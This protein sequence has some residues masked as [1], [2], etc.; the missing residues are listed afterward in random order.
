MDEHPGHHS[1]DP[2]SMGF[3]VYV[4]DAWFC[5]WRTWKGVWQALFPPVWQVWAICLCPMVPLSFGSGVIFRP[6]NGTLL[7][8]L[9][10]PYHWVNTQPSYGF[11]VHPFLCLVPQNKQQLWLPSSPVLWRVSL[12]TTWT[13]LRGFLLS[14]PAYDRRSM[15]EC[16][17][18]ESVSLRSHVISS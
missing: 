14:C 15:W 3:I 7:Y 4:H 17:P 5:V 13:C 1:C 18:Q 16:L 2:T 11:T 6:G 12:D 9:Q 8:P 10:F